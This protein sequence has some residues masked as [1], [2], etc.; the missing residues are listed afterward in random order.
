MIN[1]LQIR[2]ARAWL[3]WKQE[4]LAKTSL[5]AKRTIAEIELGSRLPYERTLRD[6]QVALEAAGIVFLFED[7][8][9]TGI[10]GPVNV[11]LRRLPDD[12]PVE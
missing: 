8:K 7:G 6:I 3:G 1:A 4:D 2:A 9:G 12:L 11:P 10:S 5:V